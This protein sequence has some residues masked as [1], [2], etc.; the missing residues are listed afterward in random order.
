[1]PQVLRGVQEIPRLFGDMKAVLANP[2]SGRVDRLRIDNRAK[3]EKSYVP[4]DW[5]VL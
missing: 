2:A 1:M 3:I 5:P 4:G